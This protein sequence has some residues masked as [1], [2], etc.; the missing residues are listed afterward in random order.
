MRNRNDSLITNPTTMGEAARRT[1]QTLRA[2]VMALGLSLT[3]A[4][5]CPAAIY[6]NPN[7]P[8]PPVTLTPTVAT[9]WIQPKVGAYSYQVYNVNCYAGCLYGFTINYPVP[10]SSNPA[11]FPAIVTVYDPWGNRLTTSSAC[12]GQQASVYFRANWNTQYTVV[13]SSYGAGGSTWL[14]YG[15]L[16]W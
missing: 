3:T 4:G 2:Y 9:Q 7:P 5:I 8:P 10:G 15:I 16:I 11:P 14:A 13:V 12:C 1:S 6:F